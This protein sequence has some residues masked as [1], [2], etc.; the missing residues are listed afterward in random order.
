MT[1][2]KTYFWKGKER[3]LKEIAELE[4]INEGTFYYRVIKNGLSIE[5]AVNFKKGKLYFWKGK[6]RTIPNIAKLEGISSTTF[7][8]K[9]LKGLSIQEIID[10]TYTRKK[11]LWK[12]EYRNLVDIAKLEKV[13]YTFLKYRVNVK[14]LPIGEALNYHNKLKDYT[15]FNTGYAIVVKEVSR[16][17]PKRRRYECLCNCGKKFTANIEPLIKGHTKSCGCIRG[18]HGLSRHFLTDS[19]YGMNQRC[20]NPC[21]KDYSKYG[22][23]GVKV[24]DRWKK[25][26]PN[27]QGLVNYVEDL[28]DAYYRA[29]E[30]YGKGSFQLDKDKHGSGLLYSPETCFYISN[31]ENC[32]YKKN[33]ISF[34]Y[35]DKQYEGFYQFCS[36]YNVNDSKGQAF[37]L[38]LKTGDLNLVVQVHRRK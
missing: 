37:R 12:G 23:I 14:Q 34:T 15:G 19:W 18:T 21:D 29:V 10:S 2:A 28:E 5:E 27:E 25:G 35:K 31:S 7:R 20:N 38:Y 26:Q 32:Q 3:S 11:H 24:C 9:L 13:S 16:I 36:D 17:Q 4:N 33:S 30:K 6:N 22:I 1:L 8:K